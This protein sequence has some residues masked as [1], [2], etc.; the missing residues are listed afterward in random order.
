MPGFHEHEAWVNDCHDGDNRELENHEEA[1]GDV[2]VPDTPKPVAESPEP[3]PYFHLLVPRSPCKRDLATTKPITPSKQPVDPKS[4]PSRAN[5][6][7]NEEVMR[8]EIQIETMPPKTP[9]RATSRTPDLERPSVSPIKAKRTTS[10]GSHVQALNCPLCSKELRTDNDGL[11]AHIDFCLSKSAIMEATATASAS[12]SYPA[13]T[14]G[15]DDWKGK[16]KAE[17]SGNSRKPNSKRSKS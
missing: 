11:N 17:G 14:K 5:T 6:P 8:T 15:K 1:T 16:R 13:L 3:E 4:G 2:D 10:S 7:N 12:G 9:M